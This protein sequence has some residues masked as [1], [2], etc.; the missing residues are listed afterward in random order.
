MSDWLDKIKIVSSTKGSTAPEGAKNAGVGCLAAVIA[1]ATI[2][3][4]YI[5]FGL[6]RSGHWI[7]G[8]FALFFSIIGAFT[9]FLMLWPQKS[10]GL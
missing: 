9:S 5:A 1:V 8:S 4:F 10:N 3:T 7:M 6:F 2:L